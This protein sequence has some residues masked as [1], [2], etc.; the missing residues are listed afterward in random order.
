VTET[1]GSL[2]EDRALSELGQLIKEA[3]S[4]VEQDL[5]LEDR[6]W[7]TLGQNTSDVLTAQTRI[8]YVKMCRQYYVRDPLGHRAVCLWTDY[9]FGTGISWNTEDEKVSG[10]IDAF[11][12][13]SA[14]QSVL[15]SRGQ[16]KSSDKVLVDGEI[17]LALFLGP[18]G[19]ATIR[20]ID[21]LEI[22]QIVTDPEDIEDVRYYKREWYTPQGKG[23]TDYLRDYT[24]E[25]AE[26]CLDMSG[27][28]IQSNEGPLVVH[29]ALNTIGQ[30]GNSLLLPAVD[31][32]KQYRRFLASRIAVMLA[33][34][35]FAWK[36]KVEGGAAA[37][38]AI[39]SALDDQSPPA[40]STAIETKGVEMTP[41]KT[42][43]GAAGAYQDGRQ[44]KLQ[45]AAA[46]GIPEQYFG[47]ISI[48]NLATAKTVELPMQKQFQS[49]QQ[50]WADTFATINDLVLAHNG[51][52]PDK[53]YV[54][55]DFPPIAPEDVMAAAKAITDIVGTFPEFAYSPDVQQA[56]LM[57]LGINNVSAVLDALKKTKGGVTEAGIAKML[58]QLRVEVLRGNGHNHD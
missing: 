16:R 52:A 11:W 28:T 6:G 26:P 44:I 43:T 14:N 49:Y 4:T 40:G 53:R 18:A 22:T 48:G 1:F 37:V 46:V 10:I 29:L 33:L 30:R 39:K 7:I 25:K 55:I 35:R 23:H 32:I 19:Q 8:N 3:T 34:A 20:R 17:F 5:A 12:N 38:A 41:I 31:W 42:D 27:A 47:D 2:I 36:S 13:A 51:V 45:V 50:V 9:T 54:D 57:T 21:P 56:A 24:N 58:N 15:S